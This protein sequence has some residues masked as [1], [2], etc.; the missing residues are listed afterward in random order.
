[1]GSF[2]SQCGTA[3]GEQACPSCGGAVPAG[4][5]F[6]A[7]CGRS[8]GVSPVTRADRTPW[9]VGVAL[10]AGVLALILVLLARNAPQSAPLALA[11]SVPGEGVPPDISSM[12]PQER[13]NRLFNRVMQAAEAGDEATVAQFTPMA[14][15]A[16]AQLDTVDADARYHAG[17][18]HIHT[19]EVAASRQLADSI[20]AQQ[21]G[22]LFGYI[23]RGTVARREQDR[24]ALDR[25]YA[26]FLEHY[27]QETRAGRPEYAEHPTALEQFRQAALQSKDTRIPVP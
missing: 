11:G 15:L 2:C 1:M 21:P 4:A 17:L 24:Q 27:D 22:H 10:A 3:L 9:I 8:V 14:L 18:L 7:G 26:G 23:I 12:S 13:F 25:A 6:C 19:G 20:L 5:R 16:Y